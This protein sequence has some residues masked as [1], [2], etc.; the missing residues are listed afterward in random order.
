M[1]RTPLRFICLI[2]YIAILTIFEGCSRQD[3]PPKQLARPVKAF[4]IQENTG[5]AITRFAGEVRPRWEATLSFRAAGKVIAR[6]V[7]LGSTVHKGQ[8]LLK[9]DTNDYGLA[10]QTL[11]AQLKFAE[12]DRNFTRDDLIRYRELLKQQVVSSPEFDR[13]NT[14]Y[15]TAQKRVEALQAQLKVAQNQLNYT[16]LLADRNGVVTA[17]LVEAGQVV[18]AGQPVIRIAQLNE[19]EIQFD[20]PEYRIS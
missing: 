6:S 1:K 5:N 8:R 9:L 2:G 17:L 7:E 19:K 10:T 4:H 14:T 11:E 3:Q 20:I 13:H 12:S 15:N 16:A 18:N